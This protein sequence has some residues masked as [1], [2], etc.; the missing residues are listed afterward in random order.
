MLTGSIVAWDRDRWQTGC[1]VGGGGVTAMAEQAYRIEAV[2]L[3]KGW[4]LGADGPA[5]VQISS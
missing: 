4:L 2:Q 1:Q 5:L 3:E